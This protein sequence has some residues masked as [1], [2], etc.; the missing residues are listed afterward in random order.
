VT[1]RAAA[2]VVGVAPGTGRAWLR[3]TGVALAKSAFAGDLAECRATPTC[4]VAA[5]SAS[6]FPGAAFSCGG[7]ATTAVV[8][9][10]VAF[11]GD[12][13]ACRAT[14]APVAGAVL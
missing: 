1:Q 10:A 6:M 4:G 5:L 2:A 13:A 8:T 9:T 14:R 3:T 7:V 11:A 12:I